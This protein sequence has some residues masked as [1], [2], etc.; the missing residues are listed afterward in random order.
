MKFS[1]NVL[2]NTGYVSPLDDSTY[3]YI[4]YKEM[5]EISTSHWGIQFPSGTKYPHGTRPQP[6]HCI[7][8]TLQVQGD[9]TK[10][11]LTTIVECLSAVGGLSATMMFAFRYMNDF[12][13][14]PNELLHRAV[15]F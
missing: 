5:A 9:F 10:R 15:Y 3:S 14:L 2:N 11:K 13:N 12:I 8:M 6:I 7:F 1:E 4:N